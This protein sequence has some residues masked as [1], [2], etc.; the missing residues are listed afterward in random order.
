LGRRLEAGE[1][2]VPESVDP[3]AELDDSVPVQLVQVPR[4]HSLVGD[5]TSA[6]EDAQMLRDR[7]PAHGE[8]GCELADGPGPAAKE[9]EYLSPSRIAERVQRMSV[10]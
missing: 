3:G 2:L 1:G 6:L 4:P 7:G 10:S 8:L 9:L 5:E